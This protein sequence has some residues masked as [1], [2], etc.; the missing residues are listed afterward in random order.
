[1]ACSIRF[2]L[3]I[4]FL[5]FRVRL[6]QIHRDLEDDGILLKLCDELSHVFQG[7]IT[8]A[9]EVDREVRSAYSLVVIATDSPGELPSQQ[10]SARLPVKVT[11]LDAN[12]LHPQWTQVI[13]VISVHERVRVG[14]KVTDLFAVD[15]DQGLNGEVGRKISVFYSVSGY[16]Y[17]ERTDKTPTRTKKKSFYVF[18]I[19]VFT[20]VLLI[21]IVVMKKLL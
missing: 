13:P 8:L 18:S 9:K 7:E 11:I 3:S 4:F 14:S 20:G 16:N 19:N 10:R 2:N 21:E 6:S 15:L 1:M 12:D 5:I 17:G